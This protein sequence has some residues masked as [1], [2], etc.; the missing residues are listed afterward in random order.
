LDATIQAC[1]QQ[2]LFCRG[3]LCGVNNEW[4]DLVDI[5]RIRG[6][7]LLTVQPGNLEAGPLCEHFFKIL[8][9][10]TTVKS[11]PHTC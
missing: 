5:A 11:M 1:T 6:L 9:P 10:K 7:N 4:E 3:I 2:L 8:S